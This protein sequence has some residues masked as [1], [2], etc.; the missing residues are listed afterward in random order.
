MYKFL[1]EYKD[2]WISFNGL[3]YDNIVLAYGQMNRWWPNLTVEQV[4]YNLK[5]FSDDLIDSSDDE[6]YQ[7][8]GKYRFYFKWTDI[9]LYVYWS[10]LLRLSKKISLKRT[11]YS[12]KLSGCT[13][14]TI[15]S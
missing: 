10:K 1:N 15:F 5:T 3:H 14:I 2:F 13:R 9:D 8:F 7:K 4:C 6:F 12:I 11:W